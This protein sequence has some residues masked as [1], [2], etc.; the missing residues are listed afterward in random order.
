MKEAK[1]KKRIFYFLLFAK[2]ITILFILAEW[3]LYVFTKAEMFGTLT[4]V[5]PLFTV[6]T[7]L[8][9]KEFVQN[10]YVDEEKQADKKLTSTFRTAAFVVLPI[11][12]IMIIGVIYGK[13]AHVFKFEEMQTVLGL[14]ESGF[15]V[16]VGQIIFALF[17]KDEKK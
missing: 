14:V 13:A 5:L 10:R 8:M 6:Y 7:T 16:Y 9:F 1:L 15:G 12:V 17:K 11:Y 2:L 4:L 3:Q